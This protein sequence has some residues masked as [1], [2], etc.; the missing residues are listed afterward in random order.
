MKILVLDPENRLNEFVGQ[1]Q[2]ISDDMEL[3]AP[4]LGDALPSEEP[5]IDIIVA[6]GSQVGNPMFRDGLLSWRTHPDTQMIP[7]W[8]AGDPRQ[9]HDHCLWPRLS[10][11]VV[12]EPRAPQDLADWVNEV[13]EWQQSRMIVQDQGKLSSRTPL[14]FISALALRN[15]TG[16]LRVFAPKGAEGVL[17]FQKGCLID[18]RVRHLC[19]AE[20]FFDFFCWSEG[21]YVWENAASLSRAIDPQ[22]LASLKSEALR[23]IQ[24]AN[25]IFHF[26]SNLRQRVG[27]TSSESALDDGAVAHF[28]SIKEIYSM[29]NGESSIAEILES[30]PLSLPRTMS[31]LAKWFSLEDIRVDQRV[32]KDTSCRVLIVDD[33]TFM[34]KALAAALSRDPELT[35]VGEAHDGIE[36]LKLIDELNPDVVTLD[37]QM[38]RMDG[39][40]ALKHIM[41]RNAK[42]VVVLSAFTPQTSPLTY[43]SFKLGAVDVLTKPSTG[44]RGSLSLEEEDLCRRVK[45]AGA[46]RLEA[47]Q[48]IR[49]RRAGLEHG[50][51]SPSTPMAPVQPVP[52]R[53]AALILCGVGGFAGLVRILL[54]IRRRD[55]PCVVL[56]CLDMPGRV[57]EA[58]LPNIEKDVA[59]PVECLKEAKNLE[60]GKCYLCSS[61]M[62]WSFERGPEAIMVKPSATDINGRQP[63]DRLLFSAG[64]CFGPDT[65]AFLL[66]GSGTDGIDGMLEVKVGG[67]RVYALSPGACLKPEL[68]KTVIKR[69]G[70]V[71]VKSAAAMASLIEQIQ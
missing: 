15:A 37:L 68:P 39:L 49:S 38:P 44:S 35:V 46:V 58:L 1:L 40:T 65:V 18:A 23:L 53:G 36:A 61:E 63:F 69:C 48:V 60:A 47:A 71:E 43:Q 28:S 27:R 32:T 62:P 55:L 19:G 11:D 17:E 34:C 14:E 2:R 8:I 56:A 50:G 7:C 13:H 25:L 66:S 42:P 52:A 29:I 33:S 24:D 31:C 4:R 22:P 51:E 10:I 6:D 21:D 16:T 57:V 54:S 64:A 3:I 9:F 59:I 5:G 26:V 12:R 70:A 30:S 67:G 45:E 41:I 20:G